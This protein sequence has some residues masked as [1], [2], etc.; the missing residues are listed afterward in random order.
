[1][2]LLVLALHSHDLLCGWCF[3]LLL[4][5]AEELGRETL[6]FGVLLEATGV[7]GE[8]RVAVIDVALD[9]DDLVLQVLQLVLQLSVLLVILALL[10]HDTI[11]LG[12]VLARDALLGWF[13][14][15]HE[16]N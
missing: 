10:G 13:H 14:A 15:L 9:G 7:L 8:L 2:F 6:D 3:L 4:V 11:T 16:R 1:M 12:F 5:V